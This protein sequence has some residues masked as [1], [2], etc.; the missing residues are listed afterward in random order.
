M[1]FSVI[2]DPFT[3]HT[4][5]AFANKS[6]S[7]GFFSLA[8]T[9]MDGSKPVITENMSLIIE[10]KQYQLQNLE[11]FSPS[12]ILCNEQIRTIDVRNSQKN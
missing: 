11:M 9:L 10:S 4:I 2:R 5:D 12:R 3:K 1:D 7:T 6:T 8:D